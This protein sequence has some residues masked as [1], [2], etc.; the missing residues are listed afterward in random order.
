[1]AP[2][3]SARVALPPSGN[4]PVSGIAAELAVLSRARN[5]LAAHNPAAVLAALD[6]YRRTARTRVLDAEAFMLEVEALV[7]AGRSTEAARRSHDYLVT[8][9]GSPHRA[10]L[11]QLAGLDD[12]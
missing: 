5:A 2:L 9:P 11:Q 1:M 6:E 10:R 7:Q 12:R 3:P 8:H 4:A